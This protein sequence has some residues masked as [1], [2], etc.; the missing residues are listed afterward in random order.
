M[1]STQ[2][3][4]PK[5]PVNRREQRAEAQDFIDSLQGVAFPNSKRIYLQGERA[6]VRVRCVRS[7][8]A[9]AHQRHQRQPA[10]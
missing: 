5:K 7:N 1:S 8:S 2:L 4:T 3:N 6:D 10:L 9:D